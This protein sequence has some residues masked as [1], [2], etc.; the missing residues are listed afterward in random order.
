MAGQDTTRRREFV[1]KLHRVGV[2]PEN[3]T[4][5]AVDKPP[6]ANHRNWT[7]ITKLEDE[8]R[9]S[10]AALTD[11]ADLVITAQANDILV[12]RMCVFFT[13][14]AAADFQF[15]F[16]STA[17]EDLFEAFGSYD[18]HGPTVPLMFHHDLLADTT[19]VLGA[20]PGQGAIMAN[21]RLDNGATATQFSFQ[22][23]QNTSNAGDTVVKSGSTI[24]Y[25]L[26]G[27]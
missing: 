25:F 13:T 6:T 14:V 17:S 8:T 12:A 24:E 10:D 2:P 21:I 11:D 16:A 3:V 23:A 22:W 27:G 26:V 1:G 18:P 20:S 9:N 7:V 19:S 15:G 5:V 4:L